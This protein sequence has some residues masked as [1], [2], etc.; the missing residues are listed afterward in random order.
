MLDYLEKKDM[1]Y[2][3]LKNGKKKKSQKRKSQKKKS[4]KRKS[5]KRKS[6]KNKK[7]V[8]G[9]EI[10]EITENTNETEFEQ[11][12]AV[13][14]YGSGLISTYNLV[15]CIV[16][17]GIFELD[18]VIGTFLTHES[19]TDYIEQQSKLTKIKRILDEKNARILKIVLF[20]IDEPSKSVYSGG[21]TTE[22]I[23][24][25]MIEFSSRLFRLTPNID[26]YSC[27]ISSLRCGKA[28]I[29]PTEYKSVLTP[30]RIPREN[31]SEKPSETFL[32]EVLSNAS[33]KKIY[34]CPF[35]DMITGT[36]APKNPSDV[37]LFVHKFNCP[38]KDKIPREN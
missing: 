30:L 24:V 5:Q 31:P 18:G 19:P 32:V 28:I 15:N 13:I 35:C 6:R 21:L 26:T 36:A 7:M 33:G 8:G 11:T 22:K 4:Q 17:G 29:S 34:K 2:K 25:L 3:L 23:I 37:S 10:I 16:V 12:Y 20:R 27:D 1:V 14:N 9:G 38:N